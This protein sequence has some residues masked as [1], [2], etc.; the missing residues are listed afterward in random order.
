MKFQ[1]TTT[2]TVTIDFEAP[3]SG[4]D[5]RKHVLPL[6]QKDALNAVGKYLKSGTFTPHDNLVSLNVQSD[7]RIHPSVP[8]KPVKR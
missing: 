3:L 5:V 6:V 8:T 2:I 4:F 1:A 7:M